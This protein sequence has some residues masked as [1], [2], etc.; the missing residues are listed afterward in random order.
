MAKVG[1]AAV[2]PHVE[3]NPVR[4][5]WRHARR[6]PHEVMPGFGWIPGK[7]PVVKIRPLLHLLD[8]GM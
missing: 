2:A 7:E 3:L 5:N 6:N 1:Q 4:P 8:D